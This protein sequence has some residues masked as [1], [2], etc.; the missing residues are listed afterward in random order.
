MRTRVRSPAL[1]SGLRIR[2]CQSCG[3]GGRCSSDPVLLWLWCRP[4]AAARIRP[5]AWEPPYAASAALKRQKDKKKKKKRKEY[6]V[7]LMCLALRKWSRYLHAFP[8]PLPG[9]LVHVLRLIF[10]CDGQLTQ[11][12]WSCCNHLPHK[13]MKR[14]CGRNPGW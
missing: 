6:N 4:A 14:K 3:A 10:L 5:L 11:Q 8:L 7:C 1:L 9:H 2:S 12:D 13:R